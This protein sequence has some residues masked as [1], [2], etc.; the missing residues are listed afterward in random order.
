MLAISPVLIR[1]SISCKINQ[2]HTNQNIIN[3]SIEDILTLKSSTTAAHCARSAVNFSCIDSSCKDTG[4]ADNCRL[5]SEAACDHHQNELSEPRRCSQQISQETSRFTTID[6]QRE[7]LARHMCAHQL[8]G[9]VKEGMVQ[10]GG[11]C[12]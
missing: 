10:V 12:E 3:R 5:P 9:Q 6:N 1:I 8:P 11:A 7:T 4:D 2:T